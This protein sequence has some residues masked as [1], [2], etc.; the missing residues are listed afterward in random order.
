[1]GHQDPGRQRLEQA[2]VVAVAA[3]GLLADLEAVGQA[4][5]GA[6]HLLNAADLAAAHRL[7][8]LVQD[9]DRDTFGMDIESYVIHNDLHKSGHAETQATYLHVTRPT[10]APFMVSHLSS[11]EGSR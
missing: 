11:L 4:L 2:V 9:T 3:A 5:E 7:S 6:Q 1:V 8:S 10:E